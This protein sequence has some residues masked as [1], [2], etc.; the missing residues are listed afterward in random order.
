MY[1]IRH[2]MDSHLRPLVEQSIGTVIAVDPSAASTM[3]GQ[4]LNRIH[5][6]DVSSSIASKKLTNPHPSVL[7]KKKMF[8]LIIN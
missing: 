1:H 2:C 6:L 7:K 4:V 8:F 5:S 3:S